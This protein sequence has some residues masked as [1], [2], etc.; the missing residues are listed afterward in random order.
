[1]CEGEKGEKEERFLKSGGLVN[2]YVFHRIGITGKD[3]GYREK[4]HWF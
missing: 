1:M 2:G 4:I 3:V